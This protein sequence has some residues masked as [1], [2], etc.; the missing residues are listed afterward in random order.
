[1]DGA[2]KDPSVLWMVD[3]IKKTVLY[4]FGDVTIKL[5]RG[6][7][8]VVEH[9]PRMRKLEARSPVGTELHVSR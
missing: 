2:V 6:G 4:L 8:V 7:V 3:K 1:M 5:K 9:L